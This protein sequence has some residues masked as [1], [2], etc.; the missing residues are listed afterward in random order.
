MAL[1]RAVHSPGMA[2]GT[3][4]LAVAAPVA[5]GSAV[6]G[7]LEQTFTVWQAGSE[8]MIASR[9]LAGLA[10]VRRMQGVGRL[11]KGSNTMTSRSY[12]R[13]LPFT[14]PPARRW[15]DRLCNARPLAN[16]VRAAAFY[17]AASVPALRLAGL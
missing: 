13:K 10:A 5:L 4:A 14:E 3:T 15:V 1:D 2:G 9:R 17:C 16:G 7:Y 12:S 6:H 11:Q 8:V